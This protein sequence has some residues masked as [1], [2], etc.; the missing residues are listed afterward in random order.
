MQEHNRKRIMGWGI[1]AAVWTGVMFFF[2][3]QSETES[4]ALSGGLTERLFG[5]L[6]NLGADAHQLE[7]FLRKAAHMG[8]FA[9]QGFLLCMSLMYGLKRRTA[10]RI[11]VCACALTSVLN[12]LHQSMGEGRSCSVADM[13]I[14]FVGAILGL[15]AAIVVLHAFSLKNN[16]TGD[17]S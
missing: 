5:W 14:D 11:T 10:V 3:G 15:L 17:Q 12:E 4:K 8:I 1:A 7:H 2:S 9:L 6:I 16:T 13:S